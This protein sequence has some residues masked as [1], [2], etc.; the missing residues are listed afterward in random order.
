MDLETFAVTQVTHRPE[1]ADQSSFSPDG[2]LLAFH[3]G[4]SVYTIHLD[5]TNETLVATGLD[6]FNAYFSPRFIG[7]TQLVF[8]RNNE[9][10]AINVDQT[11]LHYIVEAASAMIVAP[12][13]SPANDEIA[14]AGECF[15]EQGL[16][17]WTVPID[18][19]SKLCSG[20]RVTPLHDPLNNS[21]PSWG[22]AGTFAYQ[23][24]DPST[25]IGRITLNTR[26]T[27]S[28]P[29]SLTPV[30]QDSRNP[31]WSAVGQQLSPPAL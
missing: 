28:T 10:D 12:T 4:A 2:Q 9:V 22:P 24:V 27:G 18:S 6:T 3:S 8:D 21:R 13:V 14:Y 11:Q 15:G 19:V 7:D 17:I 31:S 5:G 1:G 26:T 30:G 23:R 25:S 20:G 29:C 16:S